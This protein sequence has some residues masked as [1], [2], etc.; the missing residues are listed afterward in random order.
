MDFDEE[1]EEIDNFKT[2]KVN[3]DILTKEIEEFLNLI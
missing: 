3:K 1:L 2:K